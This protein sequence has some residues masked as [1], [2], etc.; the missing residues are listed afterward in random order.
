MAELEFIDKVAERAGVPEDT[1]AL[2]T[3]NTLLTLAARISG[4]E[5]EDLADR[6][7]DQLRPYLVRLT[8]PAVPFSYE[9]FIRR[10]AEHAG[11]DRPTAERGVAAVLSA[12]RQTVGE[13]EFSDAVA[14]LPKDFDRLLASASS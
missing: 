3:G 4:G 5:A 1:A 2:I 10:V 8:E 14:Q 11:V 7:P 9:E 12:L 13:K 6:V